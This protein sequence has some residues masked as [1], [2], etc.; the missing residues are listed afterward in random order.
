[1][2]RVVSGPPSHLSVAGVAVANLCNFQFGVFWAPR[3]PGGSWFYADWRPS[4]IIPA[5]PAADADRQM[6][7]EARQ[8]GRNDRYDDLADRAARRLFDGERLTVG[9]RWLK[10]QEGVGFFARGAIMGQARKIIRAQR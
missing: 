8:A 5:L 1:M 10:Q 7:R 6:V 9:T 3:S 4:L 2:M